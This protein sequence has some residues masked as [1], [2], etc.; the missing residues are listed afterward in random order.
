MKESTFVESTS[1][2]ASTETLNN[3][4]G[5]IM[6]NVTMFNFKELIELWRSNNFLAPLEYTL[7]IRRGFPWIC[8]I[9]SLKSVRLT[10]VSEVR[11]IEA[12]AHRVTVRR[13]GRRRDGDRPVPAV[14]RAR[15]R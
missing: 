5:S 6:E 1:P 13:D 14:H 10:H 3:V 2:V 7:E 4:G 15:R 9:G 12:V 8:P 11:T